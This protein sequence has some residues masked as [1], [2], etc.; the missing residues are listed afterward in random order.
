ML[1]TLFKNN[2]YS[3]YMVGGSARDYLLKRNTIDLDLA[4]DATPNEMKKF[5]PNAD[6]TYAKF[7]NVHYKNIDITT[8][9]KEDEYLDYRHPNKI[10]FVKN[11][12][13]DF[14]RRDF[15]INAL[16]IDMSLHVYDFTNGLDDLKNK[17]IR[18]I[19]DPYKRIKEDPLRILR[20]YRF[21]KTLGFKIEE[22]SQKA[23]DELSYLLD[24]LNKD[25]IKM[26]EHKIKKSPE[27]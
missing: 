24:K 1:A 21:K 10:T 20:A 3:L 11:I 9:R 17:I 2:G 13:E 15:T 7:G 8:L 14:I 4:S 27:M 19:G 22:K 12:N 6:Y 16:Y 23:I 26:E 25:K 18:F 5:L